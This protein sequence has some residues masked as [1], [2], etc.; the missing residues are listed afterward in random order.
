MSDSISTPPQFA[1]PS[2]ATA[3]ATPQNSPKHPIGENS[4]NDDADVLSDKQR[5]AI[6]L[7]AVGKPLSQVAEKC[8][9]D[10]KTLYVWRHDNANFMAALRSRRHELWGDLA[11]QFRA[12]LP[13]AIH[14]LSN[15]LGDRNDRARWDAAKTILRMANIKE[16]L[17]DNNDCG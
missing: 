13:R 14:E 1:N 10:R 3:A 5:V 12:L 2:C 9:V 4:L 17:A 16:V 11:D 8:G 15:R 7:L 6:E